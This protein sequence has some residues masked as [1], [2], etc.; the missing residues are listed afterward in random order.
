MHAESVSSAT[1][2]TSGMTDN[3]ILDQLTNV[4]LMQEKIDKRTRDGFDSL[5]NRLEQIENRLNELSLGDEAEEPQSAELDWEAKKRAVFAEYGM[6]TDDANPTTSPT[7]KSILVG[8]Q[9]VLPEAKEEAQPAIAESTVAAPM[10]EDDRQEI[11]ELKKELRQKLREAEMELSITRAKISQERA[12]LDEKKN[13]L[14]RLAARVGE[15]K[16]T[17]SKKKSM[18]ERF[19]RHLGARKEED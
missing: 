13:D 6:G 1:M 3:Q 4:L 17:G 19:S 9:E 8:D 14:E 18:L 15:N 2:S 16:E 11:D 7:P 5:T 10:S 12:E